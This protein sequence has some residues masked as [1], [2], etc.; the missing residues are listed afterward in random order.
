MQSAEKSDDAS[1]HKLCSVLPLQHTFIIAVRNNDVN[2]QMIQ[3]YVQRIQQIPWKTEQGPCCKK[4]SPVLVLWDYMWSMFLQ[5]CL[6][7]STHVLQNPCFVN[8][9]AGK[10]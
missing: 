4:Y 6:K 10:R 3:F 7:I 8:S 1:Y 9:T 5:G 2:A